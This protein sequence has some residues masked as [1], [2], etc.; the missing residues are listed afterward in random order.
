MALT[1]K[2]NFNKVR[3]III[4]GREDIL[5]KEAANLED[6]I[7][8]RTRAGKDMNLKSFKPYAKSTLKAKS[9]A[10]RGSNVN[11][12]NKDHM[13]P[14]ITA[15]K[16]KGGLKFKFTTKSET[17]KAVWNQETRKFFGIDTN[18]IKYLNKIMSK[19]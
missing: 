4:D 1:K 2:I 15:K 16:I 6:G 8:S 17:E 13:L 14:A 7:R 9:K 5:Q 19:L 3:T 10:G 12:T 18:Q 11:L